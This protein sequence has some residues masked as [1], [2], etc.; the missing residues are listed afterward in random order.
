MAHT[1][2]QTLCC[3]T[4]PRELLETEPDAFD[5]ATCE[6]RIKTEALDE[7]N[8]DAW[9]LWQTMGTRFVKEFGIGATVLAWRCEGRAPDDIDDLIARLSVIYDALCPVAQTPTS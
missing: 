3:L 5:C 7:D 1:G 8:R 9:A 6:R 2:G 4:A